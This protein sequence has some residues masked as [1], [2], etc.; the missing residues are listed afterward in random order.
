[1]AKLGQ[2]SGL[3][4]KRG[5]EMAAAASLPPW[6]R[7]ANASQGTQAYPYVEHLTAFTNPLG[8]DS[9]AR[10][11][12]AGGGHEWRATAQL[13]APSPHLQP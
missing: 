9:V 4:A 5:R 13:M 11:V 2:V 3:V 10:R 6:K 8:A 12:P 7:G 1:M